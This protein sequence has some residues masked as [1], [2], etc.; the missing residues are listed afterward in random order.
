MA[1]PVVTSITESQVMPMLLASCPSFRTKWDA[2]VI[3]WRADFEDDVPND[4]GVSAFAEHLVE[5]FE[6]SDTSCFAD[7]FR[8]VEMILANG[9][10]PARTLVIRSL[11]WELREPESYTT[12]TPDKFQ[13]HVGPIA[14]RA[15]NSNEMSKTPAP[16]LKISE[17]IFVVIFTGLVLW[18][19]LWMGFC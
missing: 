5:R 13:K 15:W 10:K 7:V 3:E 4:E 17:W 14:L 1:D 8:T 11:I 9:D 12:G 19:A 18:L 2:L 16:S 6:A